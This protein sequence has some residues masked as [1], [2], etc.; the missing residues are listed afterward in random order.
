MRFFDKSRAAIVV[1]MLAGSWV[2]LAQQPRQVNDALLKTGSATGE[3][4]V[5]QR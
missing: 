2:N 1:A 3:E 4:W 5:A